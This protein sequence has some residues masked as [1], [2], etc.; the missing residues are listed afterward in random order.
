MFTLTTGKF[1]AVFLLGIA[2]GM[3]LLALVTPE[4]ECTLCIECDSKECTAEFT[5]DTVRIPKDPMKFIGEA[6][7]P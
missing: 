6:R 2:G 4:T 1:I 3:M 7:I 5:G